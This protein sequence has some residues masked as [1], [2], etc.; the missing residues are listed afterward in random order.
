VLHREALL[1]DLRGG[2]PHAPAA[3]DT[4][5]PLADQAHGRV[6][7][8][9]AD[10]V[11]ACGESGLVERV[12]GGGLR[13]AGAEHLH[14]HHRKPRAACVGILLAAGRRYE[15]LQSWQERCGGTGLRGF[16][17]DREVGQR[18]EVRETFEVGRVD[19]LA[20]GHVQTLRCAEVHTEMGDG[21][22]DEADIPAVAAREPK[23]VLLA[24]AFERAHGAAAVRLVQVREGE[25]A[26]EAVDA[27]AGVE[28]AVDGVDR[29]RRDNAE[30]LDVVRPERG[31][32]VRERVKEGG[33]AACC[34]EDDGVIESGLD[35]RARPGRDKSQREGC[36]LVSGS[37]MCEHFVDDLVREVCE[38]TPRVH[39]DGSGLCLKVICA[40][41]EA[42]QREQ[43]TDQRE[44]YTPFVVYMLVVK[45][46][47]WLGDDGMC[48]LA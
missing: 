7:C 45:L 35:E 39:K 37:S 18:R 6:F 15:L 43:R 24:R 13:C 31:G 33:Y 11:A 26:R 28:D 1:H 46:V 9:N 48:V 44:S 30:V 29:A 47:R 8:N 2:I 4:I 12:D 27:A 38:Y 16:V 3:T 36:G 41:T 21:R 14:E 25:P 34:G 5:F 40:W 23:E 32:F 19:R 17:H 20:L 22:T 10:R 42:C